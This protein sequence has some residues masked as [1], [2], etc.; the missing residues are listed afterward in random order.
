ML[1]AFAIL[2]FVGGAIAC[3]AVG[4]WVA[5][6]LSVLPA[7]AWAWIEFDLRKPF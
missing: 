6:A 2:V 7:L 1:K 3:A 4:A 5:A